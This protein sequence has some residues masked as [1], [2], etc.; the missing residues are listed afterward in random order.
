MPDD[1]LGFLLTPPSHIRGL[2]RRLQ[3]LVWSE[4]ETE[5]SSMRGTVTRPDE[6]CVFVPCLRMRMVTKPAFMK[7]TGLTPTLE[8]LL[9][10]QFSFL[11]FIFLASFNSDIISNC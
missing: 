8:M 10:E 1:L 6:F 7:K 3:A 11:D 2:V 5:G 4:L 9:L